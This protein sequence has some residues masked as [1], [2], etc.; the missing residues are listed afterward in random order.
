MKQTRQASD[1]FKRMRVS[2]HKFGPQAA[3]FIKKHLL[4][5]CGCALLLVAA[6][7]ATAIFANKDNKKDNVP[8][9]PVDSHISVMAPETSEEC[10]AAPLFTPEPSRNPSNPDPVVKTP[11]PLHF[12]NGVTSS[13]VYNIQQ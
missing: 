12:Y 8:N 4:P 2:I 1:A 5:V 6:I 13:S 11:V 10:T 9:I 3:G 7:V